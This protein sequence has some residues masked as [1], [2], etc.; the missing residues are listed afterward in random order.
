[1]SIL[2]TL[3][4]PGYNPVGI[5]SISALIVGFFFTFLPDKLPKKYR[6]C[7]ITLIPAAVLIL[8]EVYHQMFFCRLPGADYFVGEIILIAFG[9][10][11]SL[12]I[13][14]FSGIAIYDYIWIFN[15]R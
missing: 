11:L 5:S 8:G 2:G 3:W 14:H 9:F 13:F 4:Y 12:E 15:S 6:N 7:V 10:S 1:M